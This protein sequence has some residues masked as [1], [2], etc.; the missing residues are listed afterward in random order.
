MYKVGDKVWD[1]RYGW[2]VVERNAEE[3]AD[4]N[5]IVKYRFPVRVRFEGGQQRASYTSDGRRVENENRILMFK[6]IENLESYI[7]KPKDELVVGKLYEVWD[8][9][10]NLKVISY[11]TGTGTLFS[12]YKKNIGTRYGEAY[13]NWVR[14]KGGM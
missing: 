7:K 14:I 5:C 9:D 2:G 1:I 11:Y 8:G 3:V 4:E 12:I 6:E 13:R 10:I